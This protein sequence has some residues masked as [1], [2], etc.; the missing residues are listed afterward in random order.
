MF[1][2]NNINLPFSFQSF[3]QQFQHHRPPRRS[4]R[5]KTI[6]CDWSKGTC[7]C[8]GSVNEMSSSSIRAYYWLTAAVTHAHTPT[9]THWYVVSILKKAEHACTHMR[10]RTVSLTCV[11]VTK[12]VCLHCSVTKTRL[13]AQQKALLFLYTHMH[14][15]NKQE[16]FKTHTCVQMLVHKRARSR[17]LNLQWCETSCSVFSLKGKRNHASN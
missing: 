3:K 7:A 12:P 6:N 11:S 15:E 2:K 17:V 5:I 16:K 8:S 13:H 10:P 14:S 9:E 1:V 4:N